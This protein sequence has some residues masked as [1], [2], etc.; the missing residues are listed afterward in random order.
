MQLTKQLQHY[1]WEHQEQLDGTRV[2]CDTD[3]MEW[4][5][6]DFARLPCMRESHPSL[7]LHMTHANHSVGSKAIQQHA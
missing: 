3:E 4:E 7:E 5:T 1:N 2:S 6:D